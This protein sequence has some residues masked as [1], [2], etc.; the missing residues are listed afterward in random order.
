MWVLR[1]GDTRGSC[2]CK[3]ACARAGGEPETGIAAHRLKARSRAAR[4]RAWRARIVRPVRSRRPSRDEAR[5]C[6]AERLRMGEPAAHQHGR[7]GDRRCH[8]V[9]DRPGARRARPAPAEVQPRTAVRGRVPGREHG[10][11]GLLR[12]RQPVG[13]DPGGVDRGDEL[14]TAR[15]EPVHR[16]EH[17]LGHRTAGD[18]RADG[19]RLAGSR[20]PIAKTSSRANSAKPA[21]AQP[22]RRRRASPKARPAPPMRSS[23]PGAAD[24]RIAARMLRPRSLTDRRSRISD[25]PAEHTSLPAS[26]PRLLSDR[27]GRSSDQAA[28]LSVSAGPSDRARGRLRRLPPMR[29]RPPRRCRARASPSARGSASRGRRWS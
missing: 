25:R 28:K 26:W 3:Y 7:R 14:R 8:P 24:G 4:P 12:R 20:R 1:R 2:F 23:L 6:D 5:A 19:R 21:S 16:G 27:Q 15:Q 18:A 17:R 11:P 9:S 29:G 10:Q 13:S 22:P